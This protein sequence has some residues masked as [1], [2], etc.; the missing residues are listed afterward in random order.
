[1]PPA[2]D[3]RKSNKSGHVEIRREESREGRW[4][5]MFFGCFFKSSYVQETKGANK[6]EMSPFCRRP[7]GGPP[8]VKSPPAERRDE[9]NLS[10]Q[11][12]GADNTGGDGNHVATDGVSWTKPDITFAITRGRHSGLFSIRLFTRRNAL[13]TRSVPLVPRRPPCI[14]ISVLW[15]PFR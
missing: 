4:E 6:G 11:R 5:I 3:H 9:S 10:T 13:A 12:E 15:L 2:R 7:S 8:D 1:M 14:V